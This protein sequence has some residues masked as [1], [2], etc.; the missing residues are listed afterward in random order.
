MLAFISVGV[1]IARADSIYMT[2][3][4]GGKLFL[5]GYW[6]IYPDCTSRGEVNLRVI[7]KPS[8]GN[9]VIG[10][11]TTYPNAVPADPRSVC[12]THR[13]SSMN[14]EYKPKRGFIGTDSVAVEAISPLGNDRV[15]TYNITVK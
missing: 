13:V 14:V 6:S 1:S 10:R 11:G 2:M 4:A 5:Y 8:H 3:P 9:I 12:N 7:T 15:D